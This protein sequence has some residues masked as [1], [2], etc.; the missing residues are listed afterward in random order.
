LG[1]TIREFNG[2]LRLDIINQADWAKVIAHFDNYPLRTYKFIYWEAG[3]KI[4]IL[5]INKAHLT[6]KGI[7][8][9][10]ALKG[11]YPKGC[12][13]YLRAAFPHVNLVDVPFFVHS[14]EP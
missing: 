3:R 4:Y 10:V 6:D 11:M 8:R 2:N 7:E 13:P 14:M 5:L 1:G 9:I 12:N